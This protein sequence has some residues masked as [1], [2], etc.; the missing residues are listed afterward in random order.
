MEKNK[1]LA[2]LLRKLNKLDSQIKKMVNAP[3]WYCIPNYD[4]K[5]E[6]L[7]NK[8]WAMKEE[9]AAIG[10]KLNTLTREVSEIPA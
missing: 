4:K 7:Y 1:T 6:A 8:V 2:S 5:V 9:F 3:H 10:Y